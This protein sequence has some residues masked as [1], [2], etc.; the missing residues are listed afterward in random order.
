MPSFHLLIKG[1]VQGVFYRSSA[2]KMATK[3]GLVGWIKNTKDGNVESLVTGPSEAVDNFIIWCRQGPSNALV[4]EVN[5]TQNEETAF[6][7]FV[8]RH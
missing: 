3:L 5:V 4:S 2:K 8:I 7:D 6:P 1:K